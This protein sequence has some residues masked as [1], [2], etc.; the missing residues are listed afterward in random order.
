LNRSKVLLGEDDHWV[1]PEGL[2]I[3]YASVFRV[4]KRKWDNKGL[5]YAWY[6]SGSVEKRAVIDDL[7]FGGADKVLDRIL[8]RFS[9]ELIE[10]ISEPEGAAGPPA[11]S[12]S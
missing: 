12:S 7:K 2:K 5:A 3:P 10:K 4:D 1:S 8:S 11:D 9:G 6:R